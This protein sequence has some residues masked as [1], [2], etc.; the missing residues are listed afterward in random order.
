[1]MNLVH[2]ECSG[3]DVRGAEFSS[4]L[5]RYGNLRRSLVSVIGKTTVIANAITR[6]KTFVASLLTPQ[7]NFAT[8]A[9]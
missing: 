4:T 7:L 9:A 6:A 2:H 8:V 5:V 3:Q 1:M